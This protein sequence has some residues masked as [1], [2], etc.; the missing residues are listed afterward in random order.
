MMMMLISLMMRYDNHNVDYTCGHWE[1]IIK[2]ARKLQVTLV[3]NYYRL[4][5]LLADGCEV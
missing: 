3:R 1:N 4:T 5:D 2:Q